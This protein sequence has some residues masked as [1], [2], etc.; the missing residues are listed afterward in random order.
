MKTKGFLGKK[1]RPPRNKWSRKQ[2]DTFDEKRYK[3]N[4]E[5]RSRRG[6]SDDRYWR[7][8]GKSIRSTFSHIPQE[9]W[10]KIFPPKEEK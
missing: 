7:Q 8:R 10:D 6:G 3:A 2:W 1:I 4:E 9:R 5:L